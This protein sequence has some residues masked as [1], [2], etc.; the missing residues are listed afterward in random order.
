[1]H[2]LTG[3]AAQWSLEK[4]LGRDGENVSCGRPSD[5]SLISQ[6]DL[7]GNGDYG[8][9][10]AD[11]SLGNRVTMNHVS[12]DIANDLQD[13]NFHCTGATGTNSWSSQHRDAQSI[14]VGHVHRLTVTRSFI[15][16]KAGRPAGSRVPEPAGQFH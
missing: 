8:I 4:Y 12:G 5:K 13:E 9:A 6:D 15:Q 14:G 11:E 16:A 10:I 3:M 7:V 1:M 2:P